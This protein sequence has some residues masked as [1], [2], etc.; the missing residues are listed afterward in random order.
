MIEFC[1]VLTNLGNFVK[2]PRVVVVTRKRKLYFTLKLRCQ[3]FR[4][5]QS[6][7][8]RARSFNLLVFNVELIE[9][10]EDDRRFSNH[11]IETL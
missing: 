9:S 8:E 6:V 3:F 11:L 4:Q 10:V 5:A 1:N 7:K 2:L